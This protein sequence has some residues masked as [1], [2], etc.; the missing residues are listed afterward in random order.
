MSTAVSLLP[1]WERIDLLGACL[2]A[3]RRG[4]EIS[5]E[6]G[7]R[8]GELQQQ[9]LQL[10]Q[11]HPWCP[12][13]DAFGL[14]P[15]DMDILSCAVAPVDEPRI[16]WMY[17]ELQLGIGSFYPAQALIREMF[18]L[19]SRDSAMF[20]QR[21]QPGAPL[22]RSGMLEMDPSN[23]FQPILPTM[24]AR[25][26]ILG[27][28]DNGIPELPGAIH[29]PALATW[30]DLVLPEQAVR[31]LNEFALWVEH[32]SQVE[33]WGARLSGG[34]V[35]LFCGPSGTGK[36]CAAEVIANQLQRKLCRV[37]LGLLVST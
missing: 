24:L 18:V 8:L 7:Q 27:W 22:Q 23:H 13:V 16:G 32:R 28:Q 19:D 15:I 30:D 11:Q 2:S 1:E 33:A 36:T 29:I 9:V 5:E 17:Q 10:R 34:P 20:N 25:S 6:M 31:C 4:M 21:L 3:A 26:R 14:E 37:D 35:A 12:I